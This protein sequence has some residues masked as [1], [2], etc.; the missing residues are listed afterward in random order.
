VDEAVRGICAASHTALFNPEWGGFPDQDFIRALHPQLVKLLHTLDKDRV[1]DISVPAGTLCGRWAKRMGLPEGIVVC[2]AAFDAHLGGIGAGIKP[3]ILVK[4]IG[5]STCDLYVLKKTGPRPSIPGMAGIVHDSILPGYYGIEA[6]QSAVGDILN[7]FVKYISPSG[8]SHDTLSGEASLLKP[9]QSGLLSLDWHNGNRTIL[10]DQRLTGL[11]MGL[12]LQTCDAEIYRALIEG[13]AFG[14]RVIHERMEQNGLAIEKII[15]CGGIPRKGQLFMQI[16]ADVLNKPLY[17]SKNAETCALG[18]AIAA[19][20]NAG[21][22]P[23]FEEAIDRMTNVMDEYFTP[24]PENVAIYDKLFAL[25]RQIHDGFGT[26]VTD[27]FFN[28]MKDLLAIKES[29]SN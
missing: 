6:G 1:K 23:N 14:A 20:V 10:V 24:I 11:I 25:Y 8:K 13:T 19:A 5:T 26:S 3:G 17:V 29:Q 4:T 15:T 28:V 2:V 7:W 18:G 9:G 21:V 27:N 22:Y 16:Y 12:T